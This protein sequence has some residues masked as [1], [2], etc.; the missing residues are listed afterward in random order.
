MLLSGDGCRLREAFASVR[1][2]PTCA[3]SSSQSLGWIGD[4][5][6]FEVSGSIAGAPGLGTSKA[7]RFSKAAMVSMP[8]R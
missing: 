4:I 8:G 3:G 2:Q 6:G 1:R 5:R 7:F